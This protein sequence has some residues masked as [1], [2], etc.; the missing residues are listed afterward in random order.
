MIKENSVLQVLM[1]LFQNHMRDS[2]DVGEVDNNLVDQLESAG[3][4]LPAINQ[5]IGWLANL[6]EEGGITQV[7]DPQPHSFRVF[8]PTEAELL[9][10]DGID[11]IISLERQGI[12]TPSTREM[13]ITQAIEL[14]TEGID[15]S[16]IKW[17]T[18]MV[19][20]N[21]PDQEEALSNMELLVLEGSPGGIQ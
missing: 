5:A 15:L 7:A 17:V 20:F 1:Y 3:F 6:T 21:Q 19:L 18:L 13:V 2:C 8:N 10:Q 12:L 4:V 9:G 11:Y 14:E 16:L